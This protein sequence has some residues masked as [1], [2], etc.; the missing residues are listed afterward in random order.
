MA[1]FQW[2][3]AWLL[4]LLLL[5]AFA[6]TAAGKTIVYYLLWLAVVFLLLSHAEEIAGM[7]SAAGIVPAN[8]GSI[9]GGAA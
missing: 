9:T 8:T 4:F 5:I 6:H 2:F 7:F 1:F 3:G